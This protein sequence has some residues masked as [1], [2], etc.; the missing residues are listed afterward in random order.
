VQHSSYDSFEG[1]DLEGGEMKFYMRHNDCCSAAFPPPSSLE[2]PFEGDLSEVAL[3]MDVT[4]DMFSVFGNYGLTDRVDIG[5]AVPI[6]R[7]DL[8][9]TLTNTLVRLATEANPGIHAFSQEQISQFAG[10]N[11]NVLRRTESGDYSGIGDILLR[12]KVNLGQ[13]SRGAGAVALDLRLPTGDEEN[14]AGIGEAQFKVLGVGAVNFGRVSPHVNAGY[15]FSSGE[16]ADEWNYVFGFDASV[17]PRLS[18]AADVV[19]R[20]FRDVGRFEEGP[21]PF[22]FR[23][24][25]QGAL[26]QTTFQ[27]LQ[28]QDGNLHVAFSA[29]GFKVNVGSTFLVTTNILFPLT[30][31]GLKSSITPVFG[32]DYTF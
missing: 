15:T 5:F 22:N 20:V 26:Q 3:A 6:V 21:L 12:T 2:P 8:S 23:T 9:A 28:L 13:S 11:A 29:V 24:V 31:A 27:Q 4:T 7:V 32:F 16:V 25:S 17:I 18:V 14:L 30:D 1:K 19:G 10:S